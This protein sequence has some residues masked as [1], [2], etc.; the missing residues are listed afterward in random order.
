MKNFL[1]ILIFSMLSSIAQSGE[2]SLCLFHFNNPKRDF[3]Q[4]GTVEIIRDYVIEKGFDVEHFVAWTVDNDDNITIMIRNVELEVMVDSP[5]GKVKNPSGI[6]TTA[7]LFLS[8]VSNMF[9]NFNPNLS[10]ERPSMRYLESSLD[11]GGGAKKL[12]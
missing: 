8:L 7:E 4:Q 6:K 9:Q 11:F 12:D 1:I 10:L 2:K 3:M 5:L